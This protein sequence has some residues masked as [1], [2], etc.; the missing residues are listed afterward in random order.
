MRLRLGWLLPFS[1][2]LHSPLPPPYQRVEQKQ[3]KNGQWSLNEKAI[4]ERK[5]QSKYPLFYQTGFTFCL[6]ELL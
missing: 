6:P 3:G 5:E 1:L 4:L 2:F